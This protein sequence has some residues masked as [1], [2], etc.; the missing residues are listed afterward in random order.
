MPAFKKAK[1]KK[2]FLDESKG[3]SE[4]PAVGGN[5]AENTLSRSNERPI[6][7]ISINF[8]GIP[9]GVT[10]MPHEPVID[11]LAKSVVLVGDLNS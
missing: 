9:R 8:V 4:W 11:S 6:R 5:N 3:W 1:L 7:E 2:I 10:L